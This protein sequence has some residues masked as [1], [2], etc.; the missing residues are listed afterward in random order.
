MSV[1]S[2]SDA[3]G[4]GGRTEG[5]GVSY[6][7]L[8]WFMVI[9]VGTTFACQLLVWGMF[10]LMDKQVAKQD[11]ANPSLDLPF[12]GKSEE[13]LPSNVNG[14]S[15]GSRPCIMNDGQVAPGRSIPGPNLMADDPTGLKVFREH[16]DEILDGYGVMDK[17]TGTYRIP[18][19]RAKEL[20]LQKGIPGG[21]ANMVPAPAPAVKK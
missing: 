21:N 14:N 11:A 12:G 6:R 8:V 15:S 13:C 9:L 1:T 19:D 18:I 10:G 17:N 20:L 16:E 2:H 5:D 7:G 3:P 4:T